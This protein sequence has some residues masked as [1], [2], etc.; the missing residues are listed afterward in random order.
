MN[1]APKAIY[2]SGPLLPHVR[3]RAADFVWTYGHRGD[4]EVATFVNCYA[5][6]FGISTRQ[7]MRDLAAVVAGERIGL[8]AADR[9]A[10]FCGLHPALVWPELYSRGA[11]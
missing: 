5:E 7:G 1:R 6:R 4:C 2:P 10:L 8:S 9:L 11:A 3:A